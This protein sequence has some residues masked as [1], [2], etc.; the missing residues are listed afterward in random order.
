M[1]HI[2][3]LVVA[4]LLL[5]YTGIL[6]GAHHS[7]VL[8]DKGDKVVTHQHGHEDIDHNEPTKPI[9]PKN[10]ASKMHESIKCCDY[11]LPSAP[12]VF[13]S[14]TVLLFLTVDNSVNDLNNLQNLIRNLRI[15]R[16]HDPPELFI[17]NSSLLL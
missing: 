7:P 11:A 13:G 6:S 8:P 4:S 1:K 16:K 15:T 3:F 17:T 12:H 2:S 9:S 10:T 14:G 5:C